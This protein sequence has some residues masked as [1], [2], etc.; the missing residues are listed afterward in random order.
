APTMGKVG[1][2]GSSAARLSELLARAGLLVLCAPGA[3]SSGSC[4]SPPHPNSAGRW[5]TTPG[6]FFHQGQSGRAPATPLPLLVRPLFAVAPGDPALSLERARG[7]GASVSIAAHA[8]AEGDKVERF[9]RRQ[10]G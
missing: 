2:G 1:A 7:T 9:R 10:K 3:C 8:P 5:T 4:C 6:G